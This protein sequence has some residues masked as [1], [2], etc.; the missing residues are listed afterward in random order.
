V[1]D[2]SCWAAAEARN[3]IS[4]TPRDEGSAYGPFD[5]RM[6]QLVW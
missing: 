6:G 2:R 5:S 1:G 3:G 4:G